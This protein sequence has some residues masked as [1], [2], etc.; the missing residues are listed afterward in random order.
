MGPPRADGYHDIETV[1]HALELGDNMVFE[2]I[3]APECRIEGFGPDIPAEKNLITRAWR[4]MRETYGP[5]VA[6]LRVR[7]QKQLPQGG[8]LGGG[9][10]NA[11]ATLKAAQKLYCPSVSDHELQSLGKS[12]GSDVPFFVKGGC[13]IGTGRG[14][15]LTP[16]A[17]P[18]P[19]H[20]IL[21]FPNQ[22]IS[23][24]EAYAAL[25]RITNR[26]HSTTPLTHIT[27]ALLEGNVTRLAALIE[28]DFEQVL[29]K[30]TWFTA[31]RDLL[32][33]A[34]CIAAF[35]CGSGSTIA[36]LARSH[37]DIVCIESN[38]ARR[39]FYNTINT[40]T[41]TF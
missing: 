10:S 22:K 8:G 19:F 15:I 37:E 18:S 21:V 4:L 39:L 27:D 17:A 35:L 9:S 26:A 3:D 12:L 2:C 30:E 41:V 32:M 34:G 36:G 16:I 25:D 14:E 20:L 6:G 5:Q 29:G 23:T 31:T 24:P 13:A 28:N 7:V 38:L 1:F 33:E 40:R 11:A